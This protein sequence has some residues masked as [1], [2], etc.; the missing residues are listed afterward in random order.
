MSNPLRR[1]YET[2]P[3]LEKDGVILQYAPGVEIRVARAGGANKKF[4]RVMNSLSKPYRRAIQTET[5][6]DDIGIRLLIETYAKSIIIGWT[7][8]TKDLITKNDA[9]SAE[10]LPFT[11]DNVIEVMTAQP[12]LFNDVVQ[13]SQNIAMFRAET[14]ENDSGN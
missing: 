11:E 8:I 2:V 7:G 13:M 4:S 3:S 9:D 1:M 14:L 12:N 6:N 10:E 5:L